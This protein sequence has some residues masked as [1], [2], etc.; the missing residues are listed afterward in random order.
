[1]NVGEIFGIL[2]NMRHWNL[3]P[4]AIVNLRKQ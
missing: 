4:I 3:R 1:M 2:K